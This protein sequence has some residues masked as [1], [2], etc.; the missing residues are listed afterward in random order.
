MKKI[1]Q[2]KFFQI[3]WKNKFIDDFKNTNSDKIAVLISNEYEGFSRNG[4]I[5]TYYTTLSQKLAADGWLVWLIFCQGKE[6][7]GG[8]SNVSALRYVFSNAEIEDVLNLSQYHLYLLAEAKQDYYFQYQSIASFFYVQA[9][10]AAFPQ[11]KIY[12][13]FPD[14]NGFG[15]HSIQAKKANLLPKNCQI[16]ITIH[17]CFEWVYEAN[18]SINK[19]DWFNQSCY[20]E[21]NSFE[22]VDLAFF[23]SY[24]LKEKIESFGWKTNHAINRPYFIPILPINL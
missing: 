18:E 12:I 9:I 14:V 10:A 8:K 24:F 22:N 16:A 17:G 13:E 2:D 6:K 20:R 7:F 15:Y 3:S 19:D 23:P 4:G 11:S 5:G 1:S 21:Q